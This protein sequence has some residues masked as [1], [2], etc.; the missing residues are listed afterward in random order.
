MRG[1][2]HIACKLL[3]NDRA[4]YAALLVGIT[5]LGIGDQDVE[6]R[7]IAVRYQDTVALF[8]AL[9]RGWWNTP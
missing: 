7:A 8:A 2:L 5:K 3:I 6:I 9:G 1:I 4:K